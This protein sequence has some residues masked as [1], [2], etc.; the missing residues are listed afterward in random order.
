MEGL[1][2]QEW[3]KAVF[4][5]AKKEKKPVL[6][7]I[8][9]RWCHWCHTM[10]RLTYSKKV[11]VEFVNKNFIPVRVD[12]DARP[13][14][15]E[16]YNVGGWP[17]TAVL[18]GDGEMVSAATY[19]P[20]ERMIHFLENAIVC[21]KKYNPVKKKKA[22]KEKQLE[23]DA[24][25]YYRIVKSY[26][27]P[28]NGGFG[29]EPKFPN[30]DILAYLEWRIMKYKDVQAK[31]MLD[32]TLS[33]MLDGE[34]F[35]R[36]GGGFYRYATE[37]NWTIPHFEKML[38]DNAKMLADYTNGYFLLKKKEYFDVVN[39]T[40]FW[41]MSMMYD[42]DK[43]VFYGSQDADEA[44]CKLPLSERTRHVPPAIDK[45]IYTDANATMALALFQAASIDKKYSAI[46]LKL[47]E[48]LYKMSFRGG[49]A[50]S[51]PSE[52]PLCLFKDSLLLLAAL[53]VAFKHTNRLEWKTKALIVA[54]AMEKFYDR[55]NGG[56][57]DILASKNA[58]GKLKERRKS[59]QD[60]GFAALVLNMLAEISK[61]EKY[62][63]MAKKT[64]QALST[65]AVILGPHAAFYAI[66]VEEL[67]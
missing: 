19:V 38:E 43:G 22:V 15:N 34:I 2:W 4:L 65:Q 57:F 1:N 20:P 17:T 35:D 39:K 28:V 5:K 24:E 67:K 40:M 18:A 30:N 63:K 51:Y 32:R 26:Y 41:L 3:G 53:I 16:R 54:K 29:L 37:Q 62:K 11:I 9:A 8:S 42:Q 48:S 56:F 12:T 50:H 58:V 13:D 23:F 21:F 31:E 60:N 25:N 7:C 52:K 27:D 66:A 64:L 36:I 6:L 49:V 45:T 44:Y 10:D 14:I 59:V 61:E 46:A 55:K 33:K 47:L